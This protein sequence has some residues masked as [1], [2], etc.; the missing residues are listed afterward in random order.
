MDH[1]VSISPTQSTYQNSNLKVEEE[2]EEDENEVY[3]DE[4]EEEFIL[5]CEEDDTRILHHQEEIPLIKKAFSI[6]SKGLFGYKQEFKWFG[7]L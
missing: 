7:N 4:E 3:E 2:E 6:I 5:V 1:L